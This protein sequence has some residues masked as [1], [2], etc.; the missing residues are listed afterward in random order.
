ME[1]S[2]IKQKGIYWCNKCQRVHKSGTKVFGNHMEF[3]LEIS[4]YE[5][6]RLQF[7]RNWKRSKKEQDKFGA[8]NLP[9]KKVN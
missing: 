5:L 1:K 9:K 4:D 3:A 8:V 7:K 6:R 2:E